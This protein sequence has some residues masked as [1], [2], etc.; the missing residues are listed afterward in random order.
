MVACKSRPL[1]RERER[2]KYLC[3]PNCIRHEFLSFFFSSAPAVQQEYKTREGDRGKRGL[4]FTR[5]SGPNAPTSRPNVERLLGPC[6]GLR[7][8]FV[9]LSLKIWLGYGERIC[10]H[11]HGLQF[12]TWLGTKMGPKTV[13]CPKHLYPQGW[14]DLFSSRILEILPMPR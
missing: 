1:Q 9:I 4:H 12:Q 11:P 5:T 8:A 14:L 7:K 2:E 13:K 6:L 10:P 3:Y